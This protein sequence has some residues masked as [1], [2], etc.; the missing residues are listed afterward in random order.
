LKTW[1][2]RGVARLS[3]LVGLALASLSLLIC[4]GVKAQCPKPRR[5][6]CV[7]DPNLAVRMVVGGLGGPTSM[8]FLPNHSVN[9][10]L[11][12]NERGSGKVRHLTRV[13]P[14][15]AV[16]EQHAAGGGPPLDLS[17]NWAGIRGLLGSSLYPDFANPNPM[18]RKL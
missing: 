16:E 13:S 9:L 4:S 5:F 14:S 2:L 15:D 6:P 10:D 12:I 8:V 3:R 18:K 17:V 1:L 11:M 7:V